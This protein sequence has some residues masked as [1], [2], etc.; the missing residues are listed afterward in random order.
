MSLPRQRYATQ[1]KLSWSWYTLLGSVQ[2]QDLAPESNG[3]Q[4]Q[5]KWLKFTCRTRASRIAPTMSP[6]GSRFR[7]DGRPGRSTD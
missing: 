4:D 3:A 7:R 2:N 1:S 6:L 5:D